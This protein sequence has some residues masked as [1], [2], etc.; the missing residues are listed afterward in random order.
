[1]PHQNK[2]PPEGGLRDGI[3]AG[4]FL[5]GVDPTDRDEHKH[6][7]DSKTNHH[8]IYSEPAHPESYRNAQFSHAHMVGI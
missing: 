5:R 8:G 4:L 7:E 6:R 1:M 2:R 3:F